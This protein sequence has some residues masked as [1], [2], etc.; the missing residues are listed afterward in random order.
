LETYFYFLVESRYSMFGFFFFRQAAPKASSVQAKGPDG[1]AGFGAGRG[2]SVNAS[3][4]S[5]SNA[6]AVTAAAGPAAPADLAG[7][8]DD[9]Q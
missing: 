6:A 5:L 1:S 8:F 4:P 3:S 7:K 9:A 2:R